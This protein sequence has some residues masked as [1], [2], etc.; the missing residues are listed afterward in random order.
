MTIEAKTTKNAR[1]ASLGLLG[2]LALPGLL[3]CS[4]SPT[5]PSVGQAA[6]TQSS[7]NAIE[8]TTSQIDTAIPACPATAPPQRH[9]C[10][11]QGGEAGCAYASETCHC[12]EDHWQCK[13]KPD[14][15]IVP[16]EE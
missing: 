5:T 13:A 1:I 2:V 8:E 7:L 10:D 6:V 14:G 4:A 12:I 11:G 15:S 9:P 16:I 3:S